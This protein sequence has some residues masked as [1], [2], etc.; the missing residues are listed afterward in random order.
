M[1]E[2]G[3]RFVA[4]EVA[5]VE[6]LGMLMDDGDSGVAVL[7]LDVGVGSEIFDFSGDGAER[8]AVYASALSWMV[9]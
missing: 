4:T 9:L 5:D 3:G 7:S 6:G 8:G 2:T 1:G